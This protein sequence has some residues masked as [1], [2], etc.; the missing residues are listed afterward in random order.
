MALHRR[1]YVLLK[2]KI[3]SG[4]YRLGDVLPTQ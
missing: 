2:E 4:R 1:L 3:A